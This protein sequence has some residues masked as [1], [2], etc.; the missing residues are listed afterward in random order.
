MHAKHNMSGHPPPLG[1]MCAALAASG[2]LRHRA[3]AGQL[4]ACFQQHVLSALCM[5][6]AGHHRR[7]CCRGKSFNLLGP[8]PCVGLIQHV[9]A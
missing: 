7:G 5:P 8:D 3:V 2:L 9:V 6:L 1:V 4:S